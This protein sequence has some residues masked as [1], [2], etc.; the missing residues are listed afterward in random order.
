MYTSQSMKKL[1]QEV[2]RWEEDNK[3][4]AK[5]EPEYVAD[6]GIKIKRV[7]TPLDLQERGF[8]YLTDIG[9]PG[10]Y[11]YTRGITSTMYRT[12]LWK[13]S[14]YS[15]FSTAK[16]TNTLFRKIV[17]ESGEM[18]GLSLAFDLPTQ[19]GYDPDHPKTKGE[20]GRTGVMVKSFKDWSD[21]FEGIDIGKVYTY[22]VSNAQAAIIMAMHFVL[23]ARQGVSLK[24]L[25]GGMQNDILKEYIARGNFIFPVVPSIRLLADTL[26]Y[27]ARNVPFY[28]CTSI[29]YAHIQESGANAIHQVAYSIAILKTYM[30]AVVKRGISADDV[31]SKIIVINGH[32]HQDFFSQVAK[33]RAFRKIWARVM[34]EDYGVKNPQGQKLVLMSH[35]PGTSMTR[36]QPTNNIVRSAISCLAAAFAGVQHIGLRT[37]DEVFGIPS[38]EAEM[39]CIRTQQVVA[40]ETNIRSTVDPLGGSYF[41]ESLT[42]DY[43]EAM[44]CE[45]KKIDDIGGMVK[46]VEQGSIQ[47][48]IMKDAY[49]IQKRLESGDLPRV[50]YNIFKSEA[51]NLKRESYKFKTNVAEDQIKGLTKIRKERDTA[52]W[53]KSMDE[54]KRVA[55]RPEG[56]TNNLMDPII[57]AVKAEATVGEICTVLRGVFGEF[58]EPSPF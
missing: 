4:I 5:S 50:G 21:I 25:R 47:R 19:L 55:E 46:A 6:G 57:E 31:A 15:G 30:D 38:T 48:Q 41:V 51:E 49:N 3:I 16:E 35:N 7:Y 44:M 53:Q 45:L 37:M 27:C 24:T 1:T 20:V 54:I 40:Y 34:K 33:L 26:S 13:Q 29:G 12:D 17:K 36:E 39:F 18:A 2:Q 52:K 32:D 23:A 28:N 14:Q 22:S 8:D 11:P 56:D 10:E 43:E 42:K 9:L 58:V